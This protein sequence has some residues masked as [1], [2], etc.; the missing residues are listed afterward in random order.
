MQQR[1]KQPAVTRQAILDAAGGE[2]SRHGYCGTGI[3]AIVEA[4]GLTKGALFHHFPDKRALAAAWIGENLREAHRRTW[5][6]PLEAIRSLDGFRAFC[7]ARCLEMLPGDAASALVSLA[8][9]TAA[10]DSVLAEAFGGVFEAWRQAIATLIERGVAGGWIY[11]SIQPATE[12]AF[13]VST[14]SGF[15]VIAKTSPDESMRRICATALEGYLETL[16]P[17]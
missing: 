2:F 4:A 17:Q 8:A 14:F 10:E 7:R 5:I 16:R 3:G 11:R 12:A 1:K 15:T 6:E 9:E 13:L